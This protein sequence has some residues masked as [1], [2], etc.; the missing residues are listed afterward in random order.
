MYETR[1]DDII[2]I[3]IIIIIICHYHPKC[4]SIFLKEGLVQTN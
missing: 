3:I 2:V 1:Q 4:T